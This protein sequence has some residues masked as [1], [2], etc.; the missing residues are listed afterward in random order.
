MYH[1]YGHIGFPNISSI[2]LKRSRVAKWIRIS[3]Y[4]NVKKY[5]KRSSL[6]LTN[7]F[8]EL[9]DA[10]YMS[11][12]KEDAGDKICNELEETRMKVRSRSSFPPSAPWLASREIRDI[13]CTTGRK[14]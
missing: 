1:P 4:S 10:T 8:L 14:R 11:V 5:V 13:V 12:S 6:H 2:I 9:M 7:N 3:M